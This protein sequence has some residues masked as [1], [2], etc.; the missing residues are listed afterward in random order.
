MLTWVL[1]Q[2]QVALRGG[3]PSDEDLIELSDVLALEVLFFVLV[4][5]AAA[6]GEGLGFVESEHAQLGDHELL[7]VANERVV[8]ED[9][10]GKP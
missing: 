7:H 3:E 6:L 10:D 2:L 8:E 9:V 1:E 4:D 5:L